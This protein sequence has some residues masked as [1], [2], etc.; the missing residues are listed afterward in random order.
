M[1][2]KVTLEIEKYEVD[3]SDFDDDTIKAVTDAWYEDPQAELE[4][5]GV[6]KVTVNEVILEIEETT[7]KENTE[8]ASN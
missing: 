8:N 5:H 4:Y 6:D 3:P 1:T 2:I 7:E